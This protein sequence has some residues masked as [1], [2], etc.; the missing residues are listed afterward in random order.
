MIS[1]SD[2]SE[3]M[4]EQPNESNAVSIIASNLLVE[5]VLSGPATSTPTRSSEFEGF[6]DSNDLDSTT[7]YDNQIYFGDLM[8]NSSESDYEET[9]EG[10]GVRVKSTV[11]V[12]N[13][14]RSDRGSQTDLHNL[15]RSSTDLEWDDF[16]DKHYGDLGVDILTEWEKLCRDAKAVRKWA[17]SKIK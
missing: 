5:T 12:V 16:I 1:V 9:S 7:R 2:N 14:N 15:S 3:K 11:T 17:K 4:A 13:N 10:N 6:R 8:D